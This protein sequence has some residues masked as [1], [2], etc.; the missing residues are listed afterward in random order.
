MKENTDIVSFYNEMLIFFLKI[1]MARSVKEHFSCDEPNSRLLRAIA[2]VA[3][4]KSIRKA[5]FDNKIDR[6]T[7]S[8]KVKKNQ[9]VF[10]KRGAK[11]VLLPAHQ[12]LLKD[13][14]MDRGDMGKKL[15]FYNTLKF[16]RIYNLSFCFYFII[17][18]LTSNKK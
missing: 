14:L 7:L 11:P 17:Y 13:Y 16:I 3:E 2:E 12:A 15:I 10:K 9:S 8:I 1:E 4:G 6:S 18:R 5:G